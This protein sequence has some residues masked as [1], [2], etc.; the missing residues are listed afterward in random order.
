MGPR[1]SQLGAGQERSLLEHTH[2]LGEPVDGT[3]RRSVLPAARPVLQQVDSPDRHDDDEDEAA[4]GHEP[5]GRRATPAAP[6]IFACV[7]RKWLVLQ[8]GQTGN[9]CL[10]VP[11]PRSSRRSCR[12]SRH[13][14]SMWRY[15][16]RI[17]SSRRPRRRTS[18]ERA[19]V[20]DPD[21]DLDPVQTRR[22]EGMVDRERKGAR[23]DA[24]A[25]SASAS[26]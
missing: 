12:W 22:T 25:D 2:R 26:Q 4:G 9:Q 23:R 19:F 10:A 6:C 8:L 7:S 11:A 3:R 24:L 20:V 13:A 14:P 5:H 15:R 21:V 17:P 18:A 1:L 16:S